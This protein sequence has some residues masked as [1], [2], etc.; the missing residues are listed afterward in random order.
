[1]QIYLTTSRDKGGRVHYRTR[2]VELEK[3][4]VAQLKVKGG[5]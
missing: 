4:I 5:G 2:G 3:S 1:M